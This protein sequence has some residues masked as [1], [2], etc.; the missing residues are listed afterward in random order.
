MV[1]P[2]YDTIT[3]NVVWGNTIAPYPQTSYT[4]L[5]PFTAI[6]SLTIA[7]AYDRVYNNAFTAI[8]PTV[9]ASANAAAADV[10]LWNATCVGGYH[11]LSSP[12]YP[13]AGGCE[14]LSYTKTLDGFAMSGSII[15]TAENFQGGNFWA[16]YGNEPNPYA[17][18]PV[19]VRTTSLTTPAAG[20]I[21]ATT[22]GFAGDYAPLI[23]TTVYDPT[24][25]ETGLTS[26][27]TTTIFSVRIM[28]ASGT[29]V[30][31]LNTSLTSATPAGCSPTTICVNFYVP[32]GSYAYNV[33][34]AFISPTHF[35]PTVAVGTFMVTGSPVAIAVTFVT[36]Q[37]VTF[38]ESGLPT[39]ATWF[40]NVTGQSPR[41]STATTLTIIL[42]NSNSY[43]FTAASRNYHPAYTSPVVVVTSAVGVAVT[44]THV[45]YTVTFSETGLTSGTW[46]VTFNSVLKSGT[47]PASLQVTGIANGTYAFNVTSVAGYTR[48]P[49]SGNVTVAGASVARLITFT[50][51]S[52]P[53]FAVT[54]AETGLVS[55]TAWSVTVGITLMG[56]SAPAG[57]TFSEANGVY[58]YT[59]TAVGGYTASPMTGSIT[60]AGAPI[61]KLITFTPS[62]LP[63]YAVTFVEHGLP[64]ATGWTVTIGSPMGASA[65]ATISFS[66]HNGVY[67]YTVTP[68]PLYT[69]TPSSGTV[70]V[71]GG[72]IT[73]S[74]AFAL[75]AKPVFTKAGTPSAVGSGVM[76]HGGSA[77]QLTTLSASSFYT[78]RAV[79][80]S[81]RVSTIPS[82]SIRVST[83]ISLR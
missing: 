71:S 27:T 28:A 15:N 13:S 83:T 14:P 17:N 22:F 62:V 70:T 34:D 4:G 11:P 50:P 45:T 77:A 31:W 47:A 36:G 30:L 74:I 26:S 32:N 61:T 79:S 41:S 52:P 35:A 5:E 6:D 43:P 53:L 80:G 63:S 24:F 16:I 39:G 57:I 68:V 76:F 59:V 51:T 7:E 3:R 82:S 42:A 67:S 8:S 65:P 18:I 58:T 12:T 55:S 38:T 78:A 23:S 48:S 1:T 9:N 49:I 69:A 54:F 46:F 21:A 66:E 72:P 33:S 25:T 19:K 44:F 73:K 29:P 60:V 37:L 64:T 81:T 75:T 56:A 20:E 40:V 2:A 10:T